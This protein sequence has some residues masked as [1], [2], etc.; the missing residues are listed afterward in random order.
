MSMAERPA[1]PRPAQ[2]MKLALG[3]SLHVIAGDMA[4]NPAPSGGRDHNLLR[5]RDVQVL[6][7]GLHLASVG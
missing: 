4:G 2:K 5:D 6:D 1:Q 7:H 3:R